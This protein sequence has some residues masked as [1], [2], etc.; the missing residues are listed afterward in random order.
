MDRRDFL[1]L[2]VNGERETEL[3]CERL[4]M[5]HVD[6]VSDGCRPDVVALLASELANVRAVRV[7]H[8]EWLVDP[9]LRQ[10]IQIALSRFES[11]G[12]VVRYV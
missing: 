11:N 6:A 8:A 7:T 4:Y 12:G 9:E 3:S 1:L 2:R 5:H 10:N